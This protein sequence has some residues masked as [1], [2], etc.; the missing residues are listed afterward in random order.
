[1][2]ED[3]NKKQNKNKAKKLLR[4]IVILIIIASI[5]GYFLFKKSL[6]TSAV[7]DGNY[8]T[9]IAKKGDLTISVTES[10]DIKALNSTDLKSEVE[11]RTTIISIV[12]EGYEITKE[13]VENKKILV[14]L[15]SADI[16]ERL[17]QQEITYLKADASLTEAK[18]SLEIQIK[19]NSSDIQAGELN[20]RFSLMDFQKYLGET[21]ANKIVEGKKNILEDQNALKNILDD[22]NLGGEALQRIRDLDGDIYLKEQNLELAKSTYDWTVKLFEKEYI[23]LNK[24]E[25]DRLDKEQKNILRNKSITAKELFVDYEFPKEAQK[26]YSDYMESKRELDR[27]KS[28]ARSKLAQAQAQLG[29]ND[30]TYKL[31]KERLE[32]LKYQYKACTIIAPAPGQVVYSSST[33]RW[34]RQHRPIEIG[35]EVRERQK[36]ISIPDPT[37]MKV[38][39]KVHETWI[40]K[41][42]PGQKTL[43]TIAAFPD[44]KFTGEVIKKSPLADPENWLNPDLK[45]YSTDVKI[46]GLNESLKTGMTGK[47]EVIIKELK[48]V[49]SV[50]IQAVINHQGQKIC[51]VLEN[52]KP[53]MR[54][55]ETGQFNDSFVEITKEVHAGDVVILNPPRISESKLKANA[56]KKTTDRAERKPG[57]AEGRSDKA[58]GKPG[59]A[60]G[61]SDRAARRPKQER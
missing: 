40:D 1:M 59:E 13:D 35:G 32:K 14:E 25:A 46:I 6:T 29:S 50:P 55:V 20:V 38:E 54:N 39:I 43:I 9:Y 37:V 61:R 53:V 7:S 36:I 27:T 16:K 30:A 18:E 21:I 11:G 5:G 17:T 23:S 51:F 24:K 45:V 56:Q 28:L 44:E 12:D 10:G 57:K 42:V 47:V 34:L 22:P 31:Q 8:I 26:L 58:A 49:V 4:W 60:E 33:D 19:Q 41:I 52:G 15:D 3:L 48:N 2:V